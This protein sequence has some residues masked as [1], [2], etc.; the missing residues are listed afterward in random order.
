MNKLLLLSLIATQLFADTISVNN[1]GLKYKFNITKVR[2]QLEG[3]LINLSV[4]K[5]KC[6][7][8]LFRSFYND[9]LK[10]SKSRVNSDEKNTYQ[11]VINEKSL[12]IPK[13]TKFGK[14][15][16]SLPMRMQ[17]VKKLETLNCKK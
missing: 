7:N 12:N 5:K 2:A 16:Y 6:N 1:K 3:N 11:V 13:N 15:L 17:K 8:V 4:M 10:N 9:Y 14:Y